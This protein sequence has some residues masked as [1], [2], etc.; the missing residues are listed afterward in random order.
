M[1][2]VESLPTAMSSGERVVVLEVHAADWKVTPGA[3]WCSI[4]T[5]AVEFSPT[6]P[7]STVVEVVA[8]KLS[9]V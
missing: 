5:V 6:R 2:S 3:N 1:V 4:T 9:R 8:G 7:R